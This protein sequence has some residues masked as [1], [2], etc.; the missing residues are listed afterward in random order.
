MARC[1]MVVRLCGHAPFRWGGGSAQ[2]AAALWMAMLSASA[3]M[4]GSPRMPRLRPWVCSVTIRRTVSSVSL[5]S[6]AT[7]GICGWA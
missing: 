4:V 5:F 7:L 2:R 1:R 3:L 6:R